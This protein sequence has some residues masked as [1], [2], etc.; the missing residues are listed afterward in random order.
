M[1]TD[2][3]TADKVSV[4]KAEVI[5]KSE[6]KTEGAAFGLGADEVSIIEFVFWLTPVVGGVGIGAEVVVLGSA[7][8]DLENI[9]FPYY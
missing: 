8:F 5:V 7:G 9:L 6:D 2:K 4:G 3:A 1:S